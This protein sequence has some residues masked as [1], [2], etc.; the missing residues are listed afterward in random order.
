MKLSEIYRG[1]KPH[2][3]ENMKKSAAIGTVVLMAGIIAYSYTNLS[4]IDAVDGQLT[5]SVSK[6]RKTMKPFT[7]DADMKEHFKKFTEN[8][9][10]RDQLAMTDSGS[11]NSTAGAPMPQVVSSEPAAAESKSKSGAK[12]DDSITNTQTAGVDEGGIV[13]VHGNHLVILR[14]GRLFTV[15]VGGDALKPVSSVNAYPPG[16][17]PSGDWYDEMLVSNNT[18]VVIGYSYGRGGTEINLFD[19]NAVG[20]LAYRSTY[21]LRSNDYYSSRNYASRLIGDK[22]VFYTP[23]YLGYYNDANQQFPALRKWHKGA[24]PDEFAPVVSATNIYRAERPIEKSSVGALH[25]VTV[26]DLASRDMQCHG[27]AVLGSA[28]RVFYVSQSSVYV[29]TTDYNYRSGRSESESM[30]YKMPLDGSA[31][32]ALGVAGAPIDQFSFLESDGEQ[33]NVLV[34]GDGRGEAMWGSEYS[35]GDTSLF[36]V[37]AEAFADGSTNAEVDN[38]RSLPKVDGYTFQNRFVGDYVL[39]GSGNGWGNQVNK[40]STPLYAVNWKTATVNYL[41]LQHSVDRIEQLGDAAVVVGINGSDLYFTP[42][43]LGDR[44]DVKNPYI[45]KNAS[46]GE[47]RSHGFFYKPQ[48]ENTG[49]LGLPIAREGRS[50]YKHLIEDSA[51][52]LFIRNENLNFD[53]IGE[54]GAENTSSNDGCKASCVDWY[55]NAR[56]I[57]LK[58]RIFALLGYELVE[59][60]LDD[61]R[62]RETRRVN[63]SPRNYLPR[64]SGDDDTEE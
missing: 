6:P 62:L 23:Q 39:Y 43:K 45:R 55:G 9:R 26:C 48:D 8:R 25:T 28:G 10:Q 20:G 3:R 29:W 47:L 15:K 12:D 37:K 17:D 57:F 2:R 63:Y 32:Q 46:Q 31:P 64:Y 35:I 16:I 14:R 53:Q 33:L 51:A 42:I 38:Y 13:K 60:R 5:S 54:L 24:K 59:G 56:P 7:S 61:N 58:G 18:I 22:L 27:T 52:I 34:R 21:H 44:P 30:L 11:S 41:N 49:L 40:N 50:G 4:S 19:I 36:R 1:L